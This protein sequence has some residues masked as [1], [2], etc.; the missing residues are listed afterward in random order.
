VRA[1]RRRTDRLGRVRPGTPL[2]NPPVKIAEVI[3]ALRAHYG[4]PGPPPSN[5][6]FELILWENVAYLAPPA[7]RL[8]AFAMLKREVGTSPG[9]IAAASDSALERVTAHGILKA[10]FA[11]KLR[12]CAQIATDEFGGGLRP[13]VFGPL[14]AAKKALRRF[15]GIGE[16]GAEKILLFSGAQ[17]LLAPDSNALRVLARYGFIDEDPSYARMYAA[18]RKVSQEIGPDLAVMRDAHL[19]LQQHGMFLC[20]RAQPDCGPCPLAARCRFVLN[21]AP[22]R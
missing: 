2:R 3:A 11:A 1:S 7:R 19:L 9:A 6:P 13:V 18:G 8:A 21:P 5:D 10:K 15:P 16:P 22:E 4:P 20:K 12:A 14:A 17:A